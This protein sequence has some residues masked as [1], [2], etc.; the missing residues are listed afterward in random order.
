MFASEHDL[1]LAT[2]LL[3]FAGGIAMSVGYFLSAALTD[4][5]VTLNQA[6][7]EIGQGRAER[8]GA[9]DGQRRNGQPGPH[10]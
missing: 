7:N 4:R 2:V 8:P 9:G 6:A 1:L 10:L 3:L 5:I